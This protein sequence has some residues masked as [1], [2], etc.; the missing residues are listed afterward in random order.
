MT[1]HLSYIPV[2]DS[3]SMVPAYNTVETRLDGG[4][5]RKRRDFLGGIHVITPT[6]ILS[7]TQYTDFMGFF[8][9]GVYDGSISFIATLLTDVGVTCFHKC[10]VM[11][12]MP[13]LA[14]QSG[15]A[16]F[17]T[18]TLEV[19]PNPVRT[20]GVEFINSAGNGQVKDFGNTIT[21][22]DMSEFPIGGTVQISQSRQT[23]GTWG[24]TFVNLEGVYQI[25]SR[26]AIDTI[27]LL[28]ASG[29]NADWTVLG[30]LTPAHTTKGIGACI[31]L[32]T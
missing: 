2:R 12:G 29:V 13:K 21:S 15:D 10:T 9:E 31:L 25:Q 8:R 30:T 22:G 3:Y 4:K 17:V 5:S 19:F 27:Q 7:G 18:A 16:F 24:S 11:G 1:Q 32:P 26:P 14:S 20:Y 23:Q 28:S 6:W